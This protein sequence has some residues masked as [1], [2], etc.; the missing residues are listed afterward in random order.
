L[1]GLLSRLELS[2]E[3]HDLRHQR[4][5]KGSF[6]LLASV[7]DQHQHRRGE[8]ALP[9]VRGEGGGDVTGRCG[10]VA[11]GQ[12]EDVVLCAPKGHHAL[13]GGRAAL[14]NRLRGYR[15]AGEN[16]CGNIGMFREPVEDAGVAVNHLQHAA[17]H[18][19]LDRQVDDA[20]GGCGA[21]TGWVEDDAVAEGKGSCRCAQQT[22]T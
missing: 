18:T 7:A 6:H 17:G 14:V 3:R 16:N 21:V 15:G 8:T 1:A 12:C 5:E 4:V 10:D 19:R 13:V 22:Q 11:F 20:R 2:R 9:G